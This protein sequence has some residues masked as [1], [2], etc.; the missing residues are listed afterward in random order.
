MNR[1]KLKDRTLPSYTRGEEIFN[2][3][4]HIAGGGIAVAAC[5]LC[6]IFSALKHD[7]LLTVSCAVY[8]ASLIALYCMSSIYHGLYPSIGK[9]VMQIL[10][11]CTIYFLIFGTYMPISLCAV[12]KLSLV[13]GIVILSIVGVL[14]AIACTLTAI[15]LKKYSTFSM[16]CYILTGW[17]VVFAVKLTARALGTEGFIYLLLGGIS[18]TI[19]AVIYKIGKK[20]RYMHSVFHI[21]VVIGSILQFISV[22]F[23]VVLA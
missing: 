11:H 12:G 17:C 4:S 16:I 1:T 20:Q 3:V 6:V 10:D 7:A 14:C 8:G 5:A 15:D 21:F 19:G 18:Y 23:Y 2:S 13:R 22:F 9:K